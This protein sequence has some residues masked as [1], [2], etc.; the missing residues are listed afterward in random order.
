MDILNIVVAELEDIISR[1][2]YNMFSSEHPKAG[3]RGKLFKF[4]APS[5]VQLLKDKK[6]IEISK[7]D[8][9]SGGKKLYFPADMS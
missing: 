7:S 1:L 2:K 8:L 4:I 3:L 6:T 9:Y 5:K